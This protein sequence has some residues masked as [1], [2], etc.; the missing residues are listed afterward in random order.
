MKK[1]SGH[2]QYTI[3]Y[4]TPHDDF[5]HPNPLP[6]GEGTN[7]S[8]RA[9]FVKKW[10]A[11]LVLCALLPACSKA[12]A[13]LVAIEP[14]KTATCALDGM[15]LM[16]YPGPKGQIQYDKGDADFFCDTVEM[17]STYLAPEQQKRVM[18]VFTQ[19]MGKA[20]WNQPAG[21]WI[22]ARSAYYVLGSKRTGSM[23]PTLAT[24]AQIA[25][26]EAF[27]KQYGGKVLSF[28]ALTPEMVTLDGGVVNDKP[29]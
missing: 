15:L 27:A 28:K 12:P 26:A 19:D 5:P 17:V 1:P 4:V 23:G 20:D 2:D 18:G 13:P 21:H 25:D 11:A 29:M 6:G 9:L 16:D 14:A 22:D 7:D 24:F 10:L 8:L 3:N